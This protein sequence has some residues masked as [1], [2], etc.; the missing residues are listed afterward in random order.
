V[1]IDDFECPQVSTYSLD[2][3]D[4]RKIDAMLQRLELNSRMKDFYDI[5]FLAHTF[6]FDGRRLQEAIYET[7][8]NRGT[9][10]NRDSLKTVISLA[11]DSDMQVRWRQA[12]RHMRLP[13]LSF[14]E[15]M[16]TLLAFLAPA[17]EA[18]V[19]N[20]I[21]LLKIWSAEKQVWSSLNGTISKV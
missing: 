6:D 2:E 1:Q 9:A 5:Y 3:H 4:R 17:F 19:V 13:E 8:Q 12:V 15:V 20:E 10:Y 7:L 18:V 16:N 14:V 21:E 11:E